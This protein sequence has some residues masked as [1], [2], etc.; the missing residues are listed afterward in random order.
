MSVT[1][2][3]ALGVAAAIDRLG[4]DLVAYVPSNTVAPIIARLEE[5]DRARG[6]PP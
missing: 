5:G 3:R 2:E 4:C 1:T 6:G